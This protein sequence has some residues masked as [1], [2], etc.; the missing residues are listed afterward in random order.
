MR[1]HQPIF[2]A[3]EGPKAIALAAEIA[4]GWTAFYISPAR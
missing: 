1:P 3:A 4:D 2:L